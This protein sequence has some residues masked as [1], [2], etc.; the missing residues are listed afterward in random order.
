MLYVLD[1]EAESRG[2]GADAHQFVPD[3]GRSAPRAIAAP[4]GTGSAHSADGSRVKHGVVHGAVDVPQAAGGWI[5]REA[6]EFLCAGG[7][8]R[9]V[10]PRWCGAAAMILPVPCSPTYS[11]LPLS[12][13]PEGLSIPVA[14]VLNEE[15]IR[16]ACTRT[17]EG[18]TTTAWKLPE[19]VPGLGGVPAAI[20][21][22][23]EDPTA[24]RVRDEQRLRVSGST[25]M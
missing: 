4:L 25:V 21:I 23:G 11:T 15:R 10:S 5:D 18:A 1:G 12:A 16:R 22:D 3:Y 9:R 19:I 20:R 2:A 17:R 24:A 13:S 14:N 8:T 7:R 6:E